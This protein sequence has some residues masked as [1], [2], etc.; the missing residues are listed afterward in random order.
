MARITSRQ[1][2]D[3]HLV[4]ISGRLTSLD[5]G[6]L[7][8]VC[9]RALTCAHPKL[10]IDLGAVTYVDATARA[11]LQHLHARGIRVLR[12]PPYPRLL[13]LIRS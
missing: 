1:S 9:A 8:H 12:G 10:D 13:F 7:E 5:M 6:R 11:I 2:G 4:L 3:S